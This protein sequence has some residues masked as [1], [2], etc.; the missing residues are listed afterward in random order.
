[1]VTFRLHSNPRV[2]FKIEY[3]CKWSGLRG[4]WFVLFVNVYVIWPHRPKKEKVF[5]TVPAR[6]TVQTRLTYATT[7]SLCSEH[8]DLKLLQSVLI[9]CS[10]LW[11]H[12]IKKYS[13]PC[14]IV[15]H[16]ACNYVLCSNC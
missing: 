3:I 9:S 2:Y 6:D 7:Y 4:F 11:S 15:K 8:K 16:A 14:G 12:T 13:V 1:M 5:C 10:L